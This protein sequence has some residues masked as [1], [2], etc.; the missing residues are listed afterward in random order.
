MN[1]DSMKPKIV[2][3]LKSNPDRRPDSISICSHFKD[4][5][6]DIT[7]TALRELENEGKVI[8]H[9]GALGGWGG[10][11]YYRVSGGEK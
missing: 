11:H 6:V 1:T 7:Y 5:R 8:R 9:N 4:V 10:N 2:E 3:Y